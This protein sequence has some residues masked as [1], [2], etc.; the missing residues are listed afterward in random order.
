M[1]WEYGAD[2]ICMYTLHG[3]YLLQFAVTSQSV[4]VP[5]YFHKIGQQEVDKCVTGS[6]QVCNS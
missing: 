5:V 3:N 2:Y 1:H 4:F 6:R